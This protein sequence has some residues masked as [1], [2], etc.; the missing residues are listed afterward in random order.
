MSVGRDANKLDLCVGV[1]GAGTMG[2][3]IAQVA[4][5]GGCRVL[6][7]DAK[8]G[9]TQ[10]AHEFIVGMLNRAV[11]KGRMEAADAEAATARIEIAD[12]IP[13]LAPSDVVIEAI[14]EDI[15]IKR[16]V[17]A[18]I[19]AA[20]APDAVLATNTS[21]LSVTDVASA[22]EHPE[23]VAGFHFFNPVPLMPLVEVISGIKTENWVVDFLI[24]LGTRMGRQPVHVA[25]APGF[26][27]NQVGRGY[28]IEAAH[29]FSE[30]VGSFVDIDRI[31]RDLA[32]FRMGPFELLDLTALD[33]THPATIEIY[34]QYYHEPRYRPSELMAVRL[35]AGLLGRKNGQGFYRY[36]DGKQVVPNEESAPAFEGGTFWLGAAD[37]DVRGALAEIIIRANGSL[38]DGEHPDSQ[39]IILVTPLGQD[40]TSIAAERSLDA[41]RTVAVDALFGLDKRR[42]LMKTPVT[43]PDATRCVQAVMGADGTPVTVLHDSPGFAA[44]RI[45]AMIINI[46]A[47]VAQKGIATPDDIDK[48]VKLG[49]NYPHG[50][51]GFGDAL[52]PA[53]ILRVLEN[54]FRLYGDPR[55][56]PSPWLRRRAQLGV[57]LLTPES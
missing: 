18:E 41:T 10:S 13:D 32:G 30:G 48:A 45:V 39:S 3:G 44:Q 26:L 28:T 27:V 12:A 37:P 23:R 8:D 5:T 49:L 51:L 15:E 31:M 33:V 11:E 36:E 20:I 35:Q 1:V 21:S 7:Y 42:V 2:R 9:T 29:L 54:M 40:A 16:T 46:G 53:K 56:R 6:L 57:S 50:P 24:E 14:I 47:S 52:G 25:D 22:C 55:Y 43:S 17:F 4:A 38:D 19:E 34:E